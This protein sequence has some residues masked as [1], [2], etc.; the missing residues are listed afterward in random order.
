M[1]TARAAGG[2]GGAAKSVPNTAAANQPYSNKLQAV[3]NMTNDEFEDYLNNG[4]NGVKLD[5]SYDY[6]KNCN[7]QQMVSDCGLNDKPTVVDRKTFDQMLKS[8]PNAKVIYRGVTDNKNINSSEILNQIKNSDGFHVGGGYYGDGLYYTGSH[9]EAMSYAGAGSWSRQGLTQ[10]AIINPEAKVISRTDLMKQYNS[11]PYTTQAALRNAGSKSTSTWYNNGESQLAI[12]LG[13]DAIQGAK[14]NH[15]IILNRK[16]L[17]IDDT[18]Y[19]YTELKNAKKKTPA[20]HT[21]KDT[22]Q[23]TT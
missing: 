2:G 3:Q 7:F 19:G 17:I 5:S 1:E 14:S 16:A 10:R 23:I 13:Y 6:A 22:T 21:Y 8:D 20:S 11:L 4:L 12:K 15:L 9:T 18:N